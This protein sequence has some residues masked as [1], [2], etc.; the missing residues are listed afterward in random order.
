MNSQINLELVVEGPKQS[1]ILN[2]HS[3]VNK[4]LETIIYSKTIQEAACPLDYF[5][6]SKI[7]SENNMFIFDKS[8]S[9]DDNIDI[10]KKFDNKFFKVENKLIVCAYKEILITNIIQKSKNGTE[11]PLFYK[12]ELPIGTK[13]ID[14]EV[15]SNM[16]ERREFI[17]KIDYVSD[18]IYTNSKNYYDPTT[19][20][21]LIYYVI[22]VNSSGES[23]KEL[24]RPIQNVQQTTWE[25]IDL[26]TGK[27][28]KGLIR[29]TVEKNNS[30][31][32]FR[33][34]ENGPWYWK[35]TEYSNISLLK[36]ESISYKDSWNIRVKNGE[37]KTFSN[38]KFVRYHVPEFKQQ[39][40]NPY[41]PYNFALNRY[42]YYV[43]AKTLCLT[44]QNSNIEPSKRMH[45]EILAYDENEELIEVFTTDKAK[46]DKFFRDRNIKYKTDSIQ[47]WDNQSGIIVFN[48]SIPAAYT[49]YGNYFSEMKVYEMKE[50]SFNPLQNKDIKNYAWVIY[51]I[52]NLDDHE[53]AIHYLGVDSEG[54]V[55]YCSQGSSSGYPNLLLKNSDG[56]FNENTIV[57][58]SY[59]GSSESSFSF[60][61]NYSSSVENDFQYLVLGEIYVVEKELKSNSF[62]ADVRIKER[63]IKASSISSVAQRNPRILQSKYCYG[64]QGQEYAKNN[65]LIYDIPIKVLKEFGGDFNKTEVTKV[66]K[67]TSP[68]SKKVLVNYIYKTPSIVVDNSTVGKN[69]FTM[70]W[71]GPDLIYRMYKKDKDKKSFKVISK[72]ENPSSSFAFEDTDII[73][74]DYYYCFSIE[75][76]GIEYP[77]SNIF[78]VRGS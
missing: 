30:G 59:Q 8:F 70:S 22:S 15:V 20:E 77:K 37:F 64:D 36:P 39:A 73:K 17:Y 34:T 7:N 27:I 66:L 25:D 56:T 50:I 78:T 21:Y 55:R 58:K 1:K 42:M 41:I 29:Y 76:N 23:V 74:M 12:H 51:C 16:D 32:T 71:E 14:I 31:F 5:E 65:V 19:G 61:S 62:L 53:K 60:T 47:S 43:N 18:S 6:N 28:R 48:E 52:P 26:D 63:N 13:E 11:V 3:H 75:E 67:K 38:G 44:H 40:F 2:I 10:I 49:Y 24:L 69:K 54:I 72:M 45:L 35:G 4:Y 9:L 46:K 57:G 33:M 68:I